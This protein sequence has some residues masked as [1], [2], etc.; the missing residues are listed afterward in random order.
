MSI[1]IVIETYAYISSAWG[2]NEIYTGRVMQIQME[3]KIIIMSQY[4]RN[5]LFALIRE[6]FIIKFEY[7]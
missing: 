2:P 1:K 3:S 5:V 6:Y 7:L 4:L